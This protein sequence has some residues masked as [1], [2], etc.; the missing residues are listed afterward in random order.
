[1]I[2]DD[3][4]SGTD[5]NERDCPKFAWIIMAILGCLDLVRGFI[6][7]VLLE[8]AAQYIM[9]LDL[10]VARDDQLLLLGT[11]G[12]SNLL[13]GIMLILIALKARNLVQY[14]FLAIPVSY[15]SGAYLISRVATSSARLGGLPMMMVYIAVCLMTF[16]AILVWN[17]VKQQ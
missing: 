1:M 15:L 8:Y 13:T 6:H 2:V 10:S 14:V 9:G 12:I 4:N 16:V 7:I 5:I 17:R 11:F 3:M